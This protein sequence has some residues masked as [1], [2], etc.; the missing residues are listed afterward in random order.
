MLS[1]HDKWYIYGFVWPY[2]VYHTTS[3]KCYE[4]APN[5][6][7]INAVNADEYVNSTGTVQ[8]ALKQGSLPLPP[9]GAPEALDSVVVRI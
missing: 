3:S 2:G 7:S 5:I 6:D 1:I 4:S 9:P 8:L